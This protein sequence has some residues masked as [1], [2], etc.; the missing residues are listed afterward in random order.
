MNK[1]I[2]FRAKP[3]QAYRWMSGYY[4]EDEV[5]KLKE[6]LTRKESNT[7]AK[8]IYD[9]DCWIASC[10]NIAF[11]VNKFIH[12]GSFIYLPCK[13]PNCGCELIPPQD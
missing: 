3:I 5:S 6:C 10:C 11:D 13:C 12:K 8:W 9:G 1:A 7:M 4:F 2:L